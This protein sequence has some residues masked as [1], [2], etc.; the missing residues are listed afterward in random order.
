MVLWLLSIIFPKLGLDISPSGTHI[1]FK[2][3]LCNSG[4]YPF[5]SLHL[6]SP[7][8][9]NPGSFTISPDSLL[10]FKNVNVSAVIPSTA[11]SLYY[12]IRAKK[13]FSNCKK[14][15]VVYTFLKTYEVLLA[16]GLLL[17]HES[18]IIFNYSI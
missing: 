13:C 6:I 10:S 8:F 14:V 2:F 16:N 17:L 11:L 15:S 12:I 18:H 1:L 7:V 4:N 9:I 3:L 5:F